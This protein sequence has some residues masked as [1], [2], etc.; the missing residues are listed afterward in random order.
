[1]FYLNISTGHSPGNLFTDFFFRPRGPE[2]YLLNS[3]SIFNVD[4]NGTI[5]INDYI[6]QCIK[7]FDNNGI[8][9]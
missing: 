6:P 1:M 7:V 9:K 4:K 5:Y 8:Y 3:I 2:E